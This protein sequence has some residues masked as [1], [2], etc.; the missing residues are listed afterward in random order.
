MSP[1]VGGAAA[2]GHPDVVAAVGQQKRQRPAGRRH[3]PRGARLEHAVLEQHGSPAGVR[4]AVQFQDVAVARRH[5]VAL[6][7]VASPPQQFHLG[8]SSQ[9]STARQ[10]Q[11]PH[12]LSQEDDRCE[13]GT[14]FSRQ[15]LALPWVKIRKHLTP[16]FHSVAGFSLDWAVDSRTDC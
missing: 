1:A 10:S 6:G 9:S 4:D 8:K 12:H 3:H 7:R 16:S 14:T 15:H 5:L 13:A 11:L 2:V